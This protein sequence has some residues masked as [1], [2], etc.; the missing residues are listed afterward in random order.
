MSRP[1]QAGTQLL[2]KV[3]SCCLEQK[4]HHLLRPYA[5]LDAQGR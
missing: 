1:C 4:Y 2:F 5:W 3:A